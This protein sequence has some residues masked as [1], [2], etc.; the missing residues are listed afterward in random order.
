MASTRLYGKALADICG[1]PML[2]HIIERLKKATTLDEIVVATTT[3]S[4]DEAIV[5]LAGEY[6][7]KS[8]RGFV[9]D[10]LGRVIQVIEQHKSDIVVQTSGDNPLV[11]PEIIDYSVTAH[12][13]DESDFTY[14]AGLPLGIAPDIFS[15]GALKKASRLA[16]RSEYREHVNAYIF[17]HLADFRVQRLM[18]SPSEKFPELRLTV[19]SKKDLTLMREI[20]RRLFK[21][22]ELITLRNVIE[23]YKK[24]PEL[25]Q[26]NAHIEQLFV[27]GTAKKLRWSPD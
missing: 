7:V 25:F 13:K 23:L 22:E 19:D 26:I 6:G 9:D 3:N 8:F 18:P 10:V 12:R 11:D 4:E 16:R 5:E 24:E 1:R 14:M 15:P 17:D 21:E 2:G 27:S 20:Y